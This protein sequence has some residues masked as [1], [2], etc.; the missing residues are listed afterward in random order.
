LTESQRHQLLIEWNNTTT[1]FP[2]NKCIHHLF[3]TQVACTPDA[4][5]VIF[6]NQHLTYCQLNQRANQLAYYLKKLGV[7]P[8]VLVGIYIERSLEMIIGL[9]GILKAGG[10]YVPLDPSYPSERLAFMLQDTQLPVILTLAKLAGRLNNITTLAQPFSATS[11]PAIVCLDS[12]WEIVARE[13]E[14]NPVTEMT[15]VNLAYV[16]YTS[17]S[18]GKPK[19]VLLEH[20]GLCNLAIAQIQTF[21]IQSTDRILQFAS[22]NFDASIWEIVMAL[23]AGATLCLATQDQLSPPTPLLQLLREQAITTVTLPPVVLANLSAVEEP[24]PALQTIIVAGENCSANLVARWSPGRRFFNAYGPTE[25]TVCATIAECTDGNQPPPIGRPIANTQVYILDDQLQPVPVGVEGELYIGGVGL[26][27]GYLNRP[28]LT[29][30]KFIPNPFSDDPNA[31]LYRSGDLVRYRTDGN[32][33]FL[34]RIDQQVKIR[35]FRIELGE[36]EAVLRQDSTVRDAVVIA[37]EDKSGGDKRLIAYIVSN[38]LPERLPIR[39]TCL[40]EFNQ[41]PPIALRT[42]DISCD[43]VC[44]VEVPPICQAGIRLRLRLQLPETSE[45]VWVEGHVAWCRGGRAGIELF[46]T[47]TGHPPLCKSVEHLFKTH[48]F[49]KVIQRTAVSHLR[50]VLT[51]K[52]PDYMIPASFVFLSAL[53]LTPNGKI[54]RRA[55]PIPDHARPELAEP[56]VVPHTPTEEIVVG[57]WVDVLR[58]EKVGI[59]DNFFE[60]GG[61]SLLVTQ[62]ISRVREIFQ[63]DLPLHTLFDAPTVAQLAKQIEVFCSQAARPPAPPV[64]PQS[65][66]TAIPLSFPQQ[67]LWLLEQVNSGIPVYNEPSTIRLGGPINV[68]ALEQSFNEILRRHEALRTTFTTVAGQPMQVISPVVSFKLPVVDLSC[69]SDQERESEA[70]RLAIAEA[71][72]SFDLTKYPLFRATLMK[73]EETDHRLFLTFHHIIFDGVSLYAI[74]FKELETL[75]QAFSNG[76][77][78]PLPSPTIQYADFALWQRQWLQGEVL[79]KQLAYWK[80]Q[81][82]GVSA[83]QLPTDRPRLPQSTF[84]GARQCLVLSKNLRDAIKA[85]CRRE[86]VTLFMTLLAAFQTILYRYTMQEDIVVGTV[87]AGRNQPELASVLGDFLNTLVLR[88]DFSGNPTFPQLLKRVR[89]VVVDA[90]THQ[91][92]P[93]EQLVNEL[94]PTRGRGSNTLFQVAF[95]LETPLPT[96][97]LGWTLSQ[98][99][100]HTGTAK[101]DLL[102]ELDDRPEG[103]IGRIEYNTD[104]F[105][106]ITIVQLIGHFQT[107]LEGII[108]KPEQPISQLPLLTVEEMQQMWE[109]NNTVASSEYGI[110]FAP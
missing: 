45:E 85:L 59:Q 86:G 39:T 4:W 10:A 23:I 104:L 102:M 27:R 92:L 9:L 62:I 79:E 44:L 108:V 11:K 110:D 41:S 22:L 64:K 87:T 76:Q 21:N 14:E 54:D 28:E 25:T 15:A 55:L 100:I 7:G 51:E 8:E 82:A 34:G 12:E 103:I 24:L 16:I 46:P 47:S 40:V 88:T 71:T 20:R 81:L 48:G 96:L 78:S 32:L 58:L 80:Q 29:A 72:Q 60:L 63:M 19:G 99:D 13:S 66:D 42:E 84:R 36:I 57:I 77:P 61:H 105:D 5:A 89:Q 38:L 101:F 74:F 37:Y 50:C 106:E 67:Q 95:V 35:G 83:L 107:L 52:L 75:Y 1:A 53:P 31:R 18:T 65:H 30:E 97:E 2:H 49:V 68:T 56:F 98:L 109:W 69:L 70:H 26:A 93:F 90:Y 73:L 3:E 91:D 94:R 43:G 17:G 6:E 33:E